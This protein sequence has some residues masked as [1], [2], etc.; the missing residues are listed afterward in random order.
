MIVDSLSS[1]SKKNHF[2][3]LLLYQPV[4]TCIG[5]TTMRDYG[6]I[7][8]ILWVGY[9]TASMSNDAKYL[10]IYHIPI[11]NMRY[12]LATKIKEITN[13]KN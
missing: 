6:I 8:T 7:P 1:F 11:Q 5:V 12:Q 3:Q 4:K 9:E 10:Y 13:V 2:G